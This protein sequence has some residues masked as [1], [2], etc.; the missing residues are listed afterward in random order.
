MPSLTGEFITVG[1]LKEN[2]GGEMGQEMRQ[3]DR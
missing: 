3:V 1:I 2:E